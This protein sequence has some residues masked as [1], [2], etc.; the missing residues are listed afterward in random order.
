MK[1]VR[2][3]NITVSIYRLRHFLRQTQKPT[4]TNSGP[5]KKAE[6]NK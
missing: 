5:E 2:L 6:E 4:V 1:I 3:T